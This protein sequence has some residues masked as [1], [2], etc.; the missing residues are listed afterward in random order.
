[1]FPLSH[2][3][4]SIR[5][6][7]TLFV[8][9]QIVSLNHQKYPITFNSGLHSIVQHRSYGHRSFLLKYTRINPIRNMRFNHNRSRDLL[10]VNSL[11]LKINAYTWLH[12]GL[13]SSRHPSLSLIYRIYLP[14]IW[15]ERW[16]SGAKKTPLFL[17]KKLRKIIETSIVF[18]WFPTPRGRNSAGSSFARIQRI[19]AWIVAAREIISERQPRNAG[20]PF[21]H[22][23]PEGV[24]V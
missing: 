2:Q 15:Y 23:V 18:L 11:L 14:N 9:R 12:C 4:L 6:R 3:N 5:D 16:I 17:R 10:V 22:G 7:K 13:F 20:R 1:M 24:W 8:W 21:W 19:V